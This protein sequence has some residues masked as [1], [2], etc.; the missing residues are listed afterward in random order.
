MSEPNA[1]QII[2]V[3]TLHLVLIMVAAWALF[4]GL[5]R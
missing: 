4:G 3:V 1:V 5:G 2:V